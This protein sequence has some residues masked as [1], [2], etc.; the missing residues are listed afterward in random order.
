MNQPCILI[1][2]YKPDQKLVSLVRDL[3]AASFEKIIVVDDG[4]GAAFA[5]L[6]AE[7]RTLNT[8]VIVHAVN[9][10]KGRAMKTGINYIL[11]HGLGDFGVITADADGQHTP[12]DIR[13]IADEMARAP[14]SLVLGV[15]EFS[16]KIPLRSRFGNLMTRYIFAAINGGMI[17]DTQTGLRGLPYNQLGFFMTLEGERYEYEMNMLLALRPREIHVQQIPIETIYIED[18]KSSHFNP[19]VDSFKIYVL[20]FKFIF[21]SSTAALIDIGLFMLLTKLIPH[22]LF[23]A[24]VLAR[25]GSSMINYWVN[26]KIVFKKR[27]SHA[28]SLWRYYL[29]VS[30]IM[31]LSYGMTKLLHE[32]TGMPILA[33]KIISDSMLYIASFYLQRE[34]V[35]RH[36][37]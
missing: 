1:P 10:G 24:V 9:L 34:F 28:Q 13:K 8:P 17:R 5:A 27:G 37:H 11:E 2:A 23:L 20:M 29:V 14:D 26:H 30:L 21:S 19:I 6:F 25:I 12:T 16:G 18:N 32:T 36:H 15:R 4:G 33:S 35:Y 3:R 7:I 22:Y 31:L